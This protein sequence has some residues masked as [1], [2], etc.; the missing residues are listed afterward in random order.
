VLLAD[1][2]ELTLDDFLLTPIKGQRGPVLVQSI[3][4]PEEGLDLDA[5]QD[6]LVRQAMAR[7]GGN[8]TRAAQLLGLSRDQVRYR[9]ERKGQAVA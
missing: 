1:G 2:E 8:Q 9:L 5:L 6:E 3:V 7:T 4:L